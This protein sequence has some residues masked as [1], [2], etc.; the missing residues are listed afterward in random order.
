MTVH[1][2]PSSRPRRPVAWLQVLLV[3]ANLVVLILLG[4][5]L[6]RTSTVRPP[7]PPVVTIVVSP[8]PQSS[9]TS[10]PSRVVTP[11]AT[12]F[13]R[14]GAVAFTLRRDG[15]ADIYALNEATHELVRLTRHPAE[16]RDSAWSPDGRMLAFAS[17]RGG[18]WD[19]YL[20]DLEGG[21]LIRLTRDQGFDAGPDWSPDGSQIAFESYRD[22]NLD[23]YVMD[24]DGGN[25]RRLTTAAAPDYSP[26][27]SPDGR[28]IAFTSWRDGNQDVFLHI[29]GGEGGGTEINLT[30]SRDADE[31]DPVWS[32]AGNQLA[33]TVGRAGYTIVQASTLEW[34]TEGITLT[35]TVLYLSSTDPVGSVSSPTWA[36]DGQAVAAVH[37]RGAWSNLIASNLYGWGLSQQVYSAEALVDDPVWGAVA[38]SARAIT[39]MRAEGPADSPP[40]YTESVQSP[41]PSGPPSRP[42]YLQDVNGGDDQ[43]QLSDQVDDSFNAL[44]ERVLEQTGWDYLSILNG[45]WQPIDQPPRLGQSRTNWHVCGRA[46]EVNQEVYEPDHRLIQLVREDVGNQTWWRVFLQVVQQDGSMG[47]PLRVAPWNLS[48]REDGG[49]AVA[50]GGQLLDEVPAGYYADFTTL[51]AEYGWE[52]VPALYRWR[53]FWPDI[54]WWLFRKTDQLAWKECM[55][56]LYGLEEIETA[57]GPIPEGT[58]VP[59]ATP[60]APLQPRP[61]SR[62][63]ATRSPHPF[64]CAVTYRVPEY[65]NPWSGVAGHVQDLNGNPLPGYYAQVECPGAGVLTSRA[66]GDQRFNRFY[67]SEAAWEQACNPTAFQAMEVRVQLFNDRPDA[68]GTYQAVSGMVIVELLGNRSG[69]LGFV[70]CTL[71]WGEWR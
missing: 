15:N 57:F 19:V 37:R 45:A 24:A 22:G 10:E 12:P 65:D 26:A 58:V 52:R 2:S 31:A 25:A 39:H 59:I 47:E 49:T 56:E 54:R 27:W 8:T 30:N 23:V 6:Y 63:R 7:A 36:P 67:G 17:Q 13:D 38:M 50:Q 3:A 33:Y 14:G 11:T 16:D 20:L 69:S 70:V 42:V 68:D 71:N 21:T 43:L 55:L 44:R 64:T 9:P 5:A 4:L 29:L 35:E 51:A 28:M 41:S 48:A 61:V 53:N 18:N 1:Q 66:G 40:L 62:P 32:P 60:P 34:H 46:I